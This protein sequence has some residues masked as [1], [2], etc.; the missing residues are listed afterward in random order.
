VAPGARWVEE[1]LVD[2]SSRPLPT[3]ICEKD[4]SCFNSTSGARDSPGSRPYKARG[5]RV[6]VNPSNGRKLVLGF[7]G[8]PMSTW[9][10]MEEEE[11]RD[12][13]AVACTPC[14]ATR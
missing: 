13:C 1:V 9:R 14:A 6:R 4:G 5:A 12:G 7:E 2:E 3:P 10:T 8:L 11:A